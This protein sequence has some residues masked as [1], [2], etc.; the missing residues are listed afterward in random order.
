MEQSLTMLTLESVVAPSY[1]KRLL[2]YSFFVGY[3][4]L[5]ESESFSTSQTSLE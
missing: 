2:F 5:S 3:S 4:V 1:F